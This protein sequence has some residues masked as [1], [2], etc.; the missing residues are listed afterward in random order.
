MDFG[1]CCC[2]CE[3]F[4]DNFNRDDETD[5]GADWTE[6]AGD[7]SIA[8]NKLAISSANAIADCLATGGT[9]GRIVVVT[10]Q[11]ANTGDKIR[12]YLSRN[13]T[14]GGTSYY[15]EIIWGASGT[16]KLYEGAVEKGSA[17]LATSTSAIEVRLC[18][19]YNEMV[20]WAGTS[21]VAGTTAST[22]W[23]AAGYDA[24]LGTGATC[25]G[26][27]TFEDFS[28]ESHFTDD[29]ACEP[30]CVYYPNAT[31]HAAD[32]WEVISGTWTITWNAVLGCYDLSTSDNDAVVKYKYPHPEAGSWGS[33]YFNSNYG[34]VIVNYDAPSGDQYAIDRYLDGA[35][36][37]QQL[38]K[39]PSEKLV[40]LTHTEAAGTVSWCWNKTTLRTSKPSGMG[41]GLG[42]YAPGET[43]YVALASRASGGANF[44]YFKLL[45]NITGCVTCGYGCGITCVDLNYPNSYKV[46][47]TGLTSPACCA[48]LNGTYIIPSPAIA[49]PPT[50]T[51]GNTY[52]IPA[53]APCGTSA[54][55]V[56]FTL[57]STG[58]ELG[59]V[60]VYVYSNW[61]G[62]MYAENG[63]WTVAPGTGTINCNGAFGIDFG[64]PYS[65]G[66]YHCDWANARVTVEGL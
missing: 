7:W 64:T 33:V 11:A 20:C 57:D 36:L 3:Y 37:R 19:S 60:Q 26:Q 63:S 5:I 62:S 45:R 32:D 41:Y 39:L 31:Y 12:V 34:R 2:G 8:S 61:N 10:V 13:P 43:G 55:G 35:Y 25:T 49:D 40:W 14:P 17:A 48:N 58:I 51:C 16:V 22:N 54:G 56:S 15:A 23:L 21:V 50:G 53:P 30:C 4:A 6:V 47:L 27:A 65:D 29:P 59:F 46:V 44:R 18:G 24:A 28:L 9:N 42:Y 66:P 1:F 38:T 52:T